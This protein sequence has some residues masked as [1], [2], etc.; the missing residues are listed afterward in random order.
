MFIDEVKLSIQSGNGGHGCCSFYRDRHQPKGGPDGGDG[1]DGGCVVFEVDDNMNTLHH[2]RFHH[3]YAAKNGLGGEG[4]RK[5]GKKGEDLIIKVP[6]GTVI[7]EEETGDLIV[8]FNMSVDRWTVMDGGKGGR[9]NW[10]FKSPINQ[11]PREVEEG[12]QGESMNLELTLKLIADVGLLGF[13]NAGKSSFLSRISKARPKV[14]DYP[15]TT[16]EPHLGTYS[17]D[18]TRAIVVADIPGLIEGASEGKGLGMKF[19]RH[20]ERTKM[21]LHLVEPE[22]PDETSPME[23]VQAIR[24]ELA[25]HS[26]TLASRKQI[27]VFTKTDLN[28]P[29]ELI[30]ELESQLGEKVFAISTAT[31]EGI[32][33]LMDQVSEVLTEIDEE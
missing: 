20:V 16:M 8:D 15:F 23:R 2:L 6:R 4:K 11:T 29:A 22:A 21:L 31:G 5:H 3:K 10:H 32:Q 19:L 17:F 12:T 18:N 30:T 7:R 14:A 9:G 1:G 25:N 28:P 33:A 27:V 13:P 26:E 24:A